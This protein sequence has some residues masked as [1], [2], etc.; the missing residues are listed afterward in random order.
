MSPIICRLDY[1]WFQAKYCCPALTLNDMMG[2]SVFSSVFCVQRQPIMWLYNT[3]PNWLVTYRT[4]RS[5][6][7]WPFVDIQSTDAARRMKLFLLPIQVANTAIMNNNK[8]NQFSTALHTG[9]IIVKAPLTLIW[10]P[11]YLKYSIIDFC[12]AY[13]C[14]SCGSCSALFIDV[15]LYFNIGL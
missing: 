9:A 5:N 2:Q 1:K 4:S 12:I 3:T 11:P 7:H 6:N 14:S 8:L 15:L 13:Q 10:L